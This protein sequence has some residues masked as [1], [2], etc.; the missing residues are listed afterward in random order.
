VAESMGADAVAGDTLSRM[1]IQGQQSPAVMVAAQLGIA[2][3]LADAPRRVE[4]LAAMTGTQPRALHQLVRALAGLGLFSIVDDGRFALTPL[5]ELLRVD[6]PGSLHALAQYFAVEAKAW[7]A[8]L[9]SVRTGA[10]GWEQALGVGHYAYFAQDPEANAHFNAVMAG[11]TA[12]ALPDILSAYDFARLDTLVDVA[13]GRGTLLAGI[14]QAHPHLRG[15]LLDL[16]HVVAEAPPVLQAAGVLDR[17]KIV[18]GDFIADLPV[19][20]SAYMLKNTVLGMSDA[21]AAQL[22]HA[23]HAAMSP[24]SRLLVTGQLMATGTQPGPAAHL[25]LRMLV[26]FGEAGVRTQDELRTLLANAGLRITTIVGA[27]RAGAIVEAE[28]A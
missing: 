4:E 26:I 28:R 23:C 15:I 3:L 19:G 12:Q 6:A 24:H 16:P 17:C 8:L 9:H 27:G 22:L 21:E 10:S 14:L 5:G 2:D 25:D 13:G 1:L 11:N 18:G 7:S 20:A